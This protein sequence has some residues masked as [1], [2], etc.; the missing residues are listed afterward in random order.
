MLSPIEYLDLERY[1]YASESLALLCDFI[2]EHDEILLEK[3]YKPKFL[4]ADRFMYLGNNAL[5]QLE[6]ISRDS[7]KKTVLSLIGQ[8]ST[9]IGKRVLKERL[10]N[11]ICDIKIL[12]ERYE[13]IQKLIKNYKIFENHL[14]QIYDL[15]R[16]L[17]RIKLKK[18]HPY[19]LSYLHTS[20][21]SVKDVIQEEIKENIYVEDTL[22]NHIDDFIA[23]LESTYELDL[24]AKVARVQIR[25]N[26]FKE[27]IYP[28][29]DTLE[30]E[31]REELYKIE[32]IASHINSLFSI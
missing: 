23:H 5:E 2:I 10:L 28:L 9:A 32:M 24:C 30:K 4:T 14:K 13:L 15:E 22:I 29:I 6:I 7:S 26:F 1:P 11:P 12:N 21:N 3:M 18:L 25:E 17:R 20:I 27:G 8:T 16:I 31:Q 19:E